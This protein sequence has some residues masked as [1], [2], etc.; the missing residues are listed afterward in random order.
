MGQSG[1]VRAA[2]HFDEREV[3]ARVIDTYR[4]LSRNSGMPFPGPDQEAIR[5]FRKVLE[6]DPDNARARRILSRLEERQGD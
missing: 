2:T 1:R 5:L 4:R 3:V 6:L